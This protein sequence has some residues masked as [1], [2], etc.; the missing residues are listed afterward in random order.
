[1]CTHFEICWNDT[2]TAFEQIFGWKWSIVDLGRNVNVVTLKLV[3]GHC[4]VCCCL[5][6]MD[7]SSQEEGTMRTSVSTR[8]AS[9]VCGSYFVVAMH[10]YVCITISAAPHLR[11]SFWGVTQHTGPSMMLEKE[12][13]SI[14]C[15]TVTWTKHMHRASRSTLS[16]YVLHYCILHRMVDFTLSHN[17]RVSP[18]NTSVWLD[19]VVCAMQEP[20]S[21]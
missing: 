19:C 17:S 7:S 13:K 12:V 9:K 20:H 15:V 10:S 11:F 2:Q 8:S 21:W 3:D 16:V 18:F 1:M 14:C 6:E 4:A 5:L